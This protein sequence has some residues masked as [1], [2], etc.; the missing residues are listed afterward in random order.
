MSPKSCSSV[1]STSVSLSIKIPPKVSYTLFV[2]FLFT[3]F[4]L[5]LVQSDFYL[6]HATETTLAKLCNLK[7]AMS[8]LIQDC[9]V[10][11]LPSWF[12]SICQNLVQL[13]SL[14]F[15]HLVLSHCSIGSYLT[16]TSVSIDLFFGLICPPQTLALELLL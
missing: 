7:I 9:L 16:A 8:N 6:Y 1:T 15:L 12:V 13:I 2:Y 3:H 5:D 10:S 14:F 4:P 11:S